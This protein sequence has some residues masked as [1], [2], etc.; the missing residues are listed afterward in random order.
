MKK[1]IRIDGWKLV[2]EGNADLDDVFLPADIEQRILQ[3]RFD[4]G[5]VSGPSS[6]FIRCGGKQYRLTQKR[7]GS[8]TLHVKRVG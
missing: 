5:T 6:T 2:N 7:M 8:H 3:D 1:M 4:T